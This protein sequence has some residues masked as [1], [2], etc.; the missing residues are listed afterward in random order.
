[1]L[2]VDSDLRPTT[3]NFNLCKLLI[4]QENIEPANENGLVLELPTSILL[5]NSLKCLLYTIYIAI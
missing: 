5:I 4:L 2:V 3:T 1:M